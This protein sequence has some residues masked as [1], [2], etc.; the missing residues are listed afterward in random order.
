MSSTNKTTNY[1]LSQFLGSDKP[2][3]LADYNQ[4]MAKIDTQ[5]KANADAATAA[6]GKADANTANI[7][8]LTYLSTTAKNNLVAAVNEVDNNA[9][10]AQGTATSAY[11]LAN[12]ANTNATTAIN[13]LNLGASTNITFSN[14]S[15]VVDNELKISKNSDGS[16]CKV[17]GWARIN[18]SSGWNNYTTGDTGLRPSEQFTVEGTTLIQEVNTSTPGYSRPGSITFN[19]DGSLSFRVY[20]SSAGAPADILAIA[21]IIVVKDL[22]DTPAN[23]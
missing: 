2:A 5:M 6:D 12:T 1:N 17:Y 19:T 15:I 8:D 18:A 23:Q 13:A 16:I 22:G 3:W 21:C 10:T 9:D 7:G 4:D 20:G 11:S 14:S